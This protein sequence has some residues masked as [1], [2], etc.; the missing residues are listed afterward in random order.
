MRHLFL[1]DL[2]GVMHSRIVFSP[3]FMFLATRYTSLPE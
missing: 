1:L 3:S 2:A